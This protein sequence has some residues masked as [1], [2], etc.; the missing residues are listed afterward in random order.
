MIM[1]SLEVESTLYGQ[2]KGRSIQH[3]RFAYGLFAIVSVVGWG[4]NQLF[5]Y[6]FK[7]W[8]LRNGTYPRLVLGAVAIPATDILRWFLFCLIA[9]G[10][11]VSVLSAYRNRA[12]LASL[13]LGLAPI[14]GYL[15]GQIV[16]YGTWDILS[17]LFVGSAIGTFV[18]LLG[19]LVGSGLRVTSH[20]LIGR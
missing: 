7:S 5:E 19:F 18:G 9:C 15:T 4:V 8:P 3:L 14:L 1:P 12:L 16:Y 11:V 20:G 17:P 2:Y 10:L 6:I 13:A